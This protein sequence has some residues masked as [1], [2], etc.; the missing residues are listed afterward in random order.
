MSAKLE[1]IKNQPKLRQADT[2][3]RTGTTRPISV[4]S[5]IIKSSRRFSGPRTLAS[6]IEYRDYRLLW[7]AN[8]CA[9]LAVWLQLLTV[10]WLVKDLAE[11]S[12]IG[13]LLVV[14]VAAIN[15]L[16]GLAVNPLSGVLGDR[17]DRRKLMMWVQALGAVLALG[18]AFLA[19]SEY[20]R[21]WHAYA[22]VLISGAFLAITQPMQQVLVANTVP[23]ESLSNAYAF[24]VLTI[25]GTRIFGPFVGGLLIFWLGYFWN[26]AVESAL[27]LSVVLLLLT[28]R[29]RYV[30][31]SVEGGP[32]RFTPFADFKDGVLHIWR[33][34]R[35]IVQMMVLSLIPNTIL[36]PVWFLLP[37][38]TAEVLHAD[39]DMGGY[40]LAITG[41]GGFISTVTLASFGLPRRKGWIM[42][43][44]AAFAAACTMAFAYSSWLPAAFLF[45]ALMSAGQSH[46]RTIQGTMVLTIVPDQFRARTLSVLAYE[47]GF[48]TGASI[49]VGVLADATS[50]S[51]ALLVI[52]GLGLVLSMLCTVSLRRVR[53]LE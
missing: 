16:P 22:Y 51:M 43:L 32:R 50:A 44:S 9:N 48:L 29:L 42:L 4:R 18:F 15:T 1:T 37:L 46:Y 53:E 41:L 25:T 49:L 33:R 38:F 21:A 47:R 13:G 3:G 8:F 31:P 19:D 20:I 26:F 23:R 10:G 24:N 27:Y 35:E 11:G 14:S 30:A 17:L 2:N 12:S 36:H 28:I 6:W 7:C 40:L 34:Q 45:L 39:A 52:G 5:H